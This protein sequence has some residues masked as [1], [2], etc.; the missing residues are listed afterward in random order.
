M[1]NNAIN[2]AVV[3]DDGITI[4]EHFGRARYYDILFLENGKVVRRERRNKP[5]HHAF[6]DKEE[7][8]DHSLL[9]HGL[10]EPSHNKHVSMA[11]VIKD[12]KIVLARDM[13]SE[14]YQSML[15]LGIQPIVTDIANID[16][17]V[18]A[19]V[20]GTIIDHTQKLH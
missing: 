14:A 19:V 9:Q 6:G 1:E 4:S 12:C 2:I 11:E 10:D 5:G 16:Q 17:A 15:H 18:Q 20:D 13:G 7:H 3:T 8:Q